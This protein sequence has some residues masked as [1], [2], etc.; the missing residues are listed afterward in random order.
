MKQIKTIDLKVQKKLLY[1]LLSWFIDGTTEKN[2]T[3][4]C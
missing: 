3:V 2:Q 4:V 1:G